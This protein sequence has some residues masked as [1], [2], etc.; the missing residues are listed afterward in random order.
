MKIVVDLQGAQNESRHRGIGRYALAFVKALIRNKGAHEVVVL[1]SDLFPESLAYAQDA[2]GEQRAH[3]TIKIW[4]GIGPTDLRKPENHWRKHVS[5]LL[6]EAFITELKPDVLIISSLLDSPGDNTIVSVSKLAPVYTVAM[7]YDLIPLLYKSEY[8]VDPTTQDWY[9]E[10]LWQFKKADFWFAISES[11]R[12]DGI[13]QLGLPAAQVHHISAALG[14]DIVA[15][16]L[17]VEQAAALKQKFGITRPFLL[18]SGAFDPR[19]NIDRLVYA[20]AAQ[21][22]EIRQTHQLVLAGGLNAPQLVHVNQLINQ[23]GLDASLVIVTQRITDHELCALYGLCKAYIL[24]TYCEGFGFTALEA[25][26]CGAPTI[27]SNYSSVPEVI[28]LPEALFDPFSVESIA[29]KITQV[30]NDESYRAMLVAHGPKQVQTFSWD[31]TACKALDALER[32]EQSGALGAKLRSVVQPIAT[33]EPLTT[34]LTNTSARPQSKLPSAVA[35]VTEITARIAAF[36]QTSQRPAVEL[37]E[38]AAL[39]AGLLPRQDTRPRLFVDITELHA[40]DSKSGIQRVVRSVI[41][42]LI[43]DTEAA[44]KVELVYAAKP[45]GYKTATAFTRRMFGETQTVAGADTYIRPQAGD[46]FL[47]LDLHFNID[48]DHEHFFSQARRGGAQVYFVVY[49]L[50]PLLLKDTFT[51]ELVEKYGNWLRVVSQQHGAVCISQAVAAELKAWVAQNQPAAAQTFKIDWFHL[52]ADIE[53]SIPSKGVP[54]DGPK[55]L[56]QLAAQPSFL[57]VGTLEPRKRHGQMLD[58]FEQLWAQNVAANLIIVG[59]PGWLTE[60][61]TTRL[62]AHAQLGRQLFWVQSASDEYLEKIYA[63]ASCLI[64]A[65]EAE[66]FGLPL[67]EAA[68]H[69]LP[70]IARDIPV[71]REVAQD[72]ALYFAGDD[73]AALATAVQGWLALAKQQKTPDSRQIQRQTWAQSAQQLLSRVISAKDVTKIA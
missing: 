64:A 57:A 18:Y 54:D 6:R 60:A 41:Q 13:A 39:V 52:G 70:I 20:Y 4:S 37:Q 58:A 30:L 55:L 16:D 22:A 50:L 33:L 56:Q 32:L 29:S 7:L 15:V 38:T 9:Y 27:G 21:P 59:K 5:E 44:Y 3:C 24:P 25:M 45:V 35:L 68:R 49:D 73:G 31:H 72:H 28:G 63:A 19:K 12:N 48:Q 43:T 62:S 2:L 65:S 11:S 40:T 14:E 67:I 69:G 46:I 8:L 51:P 10:R 66:G 34:P 36:A 47:G 42:H 61:L 17:N 1:L 71:F 26:A 23:A 53:S